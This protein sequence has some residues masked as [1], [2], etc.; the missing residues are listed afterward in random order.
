[1]KK[2]LFILAITLT[3]GLVAFQTANAGPGRGWGPGN[4]NGPYA[5]AAN[6]KQW[7]QFKKDTAELRQ[8][9]REK[10]RA[11]FDLMHGEQVDK[12]AAEALWSDMFDLRAQIKAK[13]AADGLQMPT[14]GF[15]RGR[16]GRHHRRGGCDCQGPRG[17][18]Y[19]ADGPMVSPDEAPAPGP[20]S[21]QTDQR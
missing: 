8:Q 4:C 19:S 2:T 12:K 13:A 20:A 14:K 7:Q 11:Y 17:V 21:G 6:S 18:G 5:N 9:L 15:G 1:M 16:F 3:F 10:R